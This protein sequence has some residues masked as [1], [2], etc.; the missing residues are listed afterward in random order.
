[1]KY[2]G[3]EF[4]LVGDGTPDTVIDWICPTCKSTHTLRLSHEEGAYFRDKTGVLDEAGFRCI[5]ESDVD[6]LRCDCDLV[7]C[8]ELE[9]AAEQ[10]AGLID[11]GY[12]EEEMQYP[13]SSR[14]IRC[15]QCQQRHP[16]INTAGHWTYCWA[17]PRQGEPPPPWWATECSCGQTLYVVV[18][19]TALITLITG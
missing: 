4:T 1:M 12:R 18:Q 13:P 11:V 6:Y 14:S 8:R 17:S 3:I 16:P 15:P 5:V 10:V 2:C 19:S 9:A 7:G